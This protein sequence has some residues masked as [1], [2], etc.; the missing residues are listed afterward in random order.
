MTIRLGLKHIFLFLSQICH[1]SRKPEAGRPFGLRQTLIIVETNGF[2]GSSVNVILTRKT[3]CQ[4]SS[5][6]AGP[7]LVTLKANTE[8]TGSWVLNGLIEVFAIRF[9]DPE[10]KIS[11]TKN[12]SREF[13]SS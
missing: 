12:D 8:G 7:G 9:R 10:Y 3:C 5:R 11:T 1:L 13:K 4:R 2:V 6:A